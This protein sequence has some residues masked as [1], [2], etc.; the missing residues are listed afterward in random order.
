LKKRF[1]LDLIQ[2]NLKTEQHQQDERK[3]IPYRMRFLLYNIRYGTG[4]KN[5]YHLPVPYA[6]FFKKTEENLDQIVNFIKSAK[7]DVVALIEVDSGSYRAGKCCQADYIGQKLNFN[8]IVGTKYAN[9]SIVQK[10]PVL[11]Q[12][13][14][15]LLT[16]QEIVDFHFKYFDEGVKRLIIQAE[17]KDVII[18][19]VHLSLKF[20]HRQHQLAHLQQLIKETDKHVIVAGDFNTFR[21]NRELELF[22]SATNLRNANLTN[23]PSHPSHS[24]HRQLDFILHSPGLRAENFKIPNI[25]LSDHAPLVC[26]FNC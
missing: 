26:D 8:H 14:N 17:L 13:S 5:K 10:V 24:P 23:Q 11:K 6:G 19:I 4:H 25:R 15:A 20:R 9:G 12:Q 1:A 7:P 3:S 21:G 22:L 16:N 2:C 18:F